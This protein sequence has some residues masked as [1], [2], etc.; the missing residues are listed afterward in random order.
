MTGKRPSKREEEIC[1]W[2]GGRGSKKKEDKKKEE[3]EKEEKRERKGGLQE[4]G[5]T[6]CRDVDYI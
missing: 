2:T 3:E 1:N 6:Y 4:P 5:Q